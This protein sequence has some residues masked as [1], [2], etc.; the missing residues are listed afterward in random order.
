VL[1]GG[2]GLYWRCRN[3]GTWNAGPAV[4]GRGQ[5]L[6]RDTVLGAPGKRRRASTLPDQPESPTKRIRR[7][8]EPRAN[9]ARTEPETNEPASTPLWQRLLY[10]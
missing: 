2:R 6:V 7:Q 9:P 5:E 4:L 1:R 10:G 3:C 8:P